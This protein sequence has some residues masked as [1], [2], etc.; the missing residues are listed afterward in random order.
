[1]ANEWLA[2]ITSAKYQI[3]HISS[4]NKGVKLAKVSFGKKNFF[5]T[6]YKSKSFEVYFVEQN[7]DDITDVM[8]A[9]H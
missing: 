7:R 2:V 4:K 9:S 3:D 8:T 1:M 5:P 6:K